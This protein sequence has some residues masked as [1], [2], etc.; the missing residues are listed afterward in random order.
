MGAGI[1]K[2]NVLISFS[3]TIEI[4]E[5]SDGMIA[6]RAML[7][8]EEFC[9]ECTIYERRLRVQVIASKTNKKTKEL[10][11]SILR[12]TGH[13]HYEITHKYRSDLK[14]LEHI[15][16]CQQNRASFKNNV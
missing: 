10:V 5:I 2:H 14:Q 16:L 11:Y 3:P 1:L 4:C 15:L 13:R 7:G 6:L 12:C 9:I 8:A